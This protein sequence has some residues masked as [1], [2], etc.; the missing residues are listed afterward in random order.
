MYKYVSKSRNADCMCSTFTPEREELCVFAIIRFRARLARRDI[1]NTL[2]AQNRG[3]STRKHSTAQYGSTATE[4]RRHRHEL[5]TRTVQSNT[6]LS[7]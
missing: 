6:K 4:S 7:L 5:A 1:R 3:E 2:L